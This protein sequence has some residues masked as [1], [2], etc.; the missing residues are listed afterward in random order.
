MQSVLILVI[1]IAAMLCLPAR[2]AAQEATAF[3]L[4]EESRFWIQGTTTVNSFTCEVQAVRGEGVVPRVPASALPVA[5][6]RSASLDV[7]VQQFDCGN[8]RM[9]SDLRETLHAGDHPRI[10]FRLEKVEAIEPPSDTTT[11]WY[12]LQVLGTLTI[13]G[14]ERLVRIS[15]WGRSVDDDVYRVSGCKDLKMTYFGVEPPT[16]FMSLVKVKDRI[17]AHFDLLVESPREI[18]PIASL[19][20]ELSSPPSCK[21]E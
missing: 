14:T 6:D 15:A 10:T 21:D 9:S 8:E 12:R 3:E 18:S 20:S 7:P 19:P 17:V 13:A 4:L 11:E 16:K 5:L 1:A 2:S